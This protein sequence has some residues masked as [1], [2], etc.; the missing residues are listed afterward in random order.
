[1]PLKQTALKL[2]CKLGCLGPQE[3]EVVGPIPI[4]P[5]LE[6]EEEQDSE[7]GR[8]YQAFV[9]NEAR[10]YWQDISNVGSLIKPTPV[11]I[12]FDVFPIRLDAMFRAH[13]RKHYTE[14][15]INAMQPGLEPG[16]DL[17]TE[18]G[19]PYQ[20]FVESEVRKYWQE[21]GNVRNLTKPNREEIQATAM[22]IL[23]QALRNR[24]GHR[25]HHAVAGMV[26]HAMERGWI[27]RHS[28]SEAGESPSYIEA[29]I[30]LADDANWLAREIPLP[31]HPPPKHPPIYY[32]IGS[33]Y[34][35]PAPVPRDDALIRGDYLYKRNGSRLTEDKYIFPIRFLGGGTSR[36]PL[37]SSRLP[38]FTSD[39]IDV[40]RNSLDGIRPVYYGLAFERA[41]KPLNQRGIDVWIDWKDEVS[42]MS[43]YFS[44]KLRGLPFPIDLHFSPYPPDR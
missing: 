39:L 33:K 24:T 9:E 23:I 20:S 1:M 14:A 42:D 38:L 7:P 30:Q 2:A 22:P 5:G 8:P 18:P 15:E 26:Q 6:P 11:D 31:D 21:I 34:G 43:Y 44:S 32:T 17:T 35:R 16:E 12:G 27:R 13:S 40:D 19:R 3:Q 41:R 36:N 25:R 37:F 4:Q 10:Q 29:L 28:F